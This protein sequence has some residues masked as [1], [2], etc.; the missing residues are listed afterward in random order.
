MYFPHCH[1][2]I[3]RKD[4]FCCLVSRTHETVSGTYGDQKRVPDPLKLV[5]GCCEPP[6]EYWEPESSLR[7]ANVFYY[8]NHLSC[9]GT[10]VFLTRQLN[11]LL[12]DILTIF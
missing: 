5:P 10:D 1:R 12:F 7:A 4:F 3:K 9:P 11:I 2:E 8:R 6:Y